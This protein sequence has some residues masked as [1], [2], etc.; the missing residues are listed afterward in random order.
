MYGSTLDVIKKQ[1]DLVITFPADIGIKFGK[2]KCAV[3]RVEKSKILN[4]D[5]PL[6]I[7]NL[8]TTPIIKGETYK[9]LGQDKN[10]AYKGRFNKERLSREYVK[11]GNLNSQHLI[12]KSPITVLP[13]LY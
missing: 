10:I 5:T 12:S 9:Y 3:M 8:K 2:D 11:Y 1:L 7:T 13:Y 4:S 6:K